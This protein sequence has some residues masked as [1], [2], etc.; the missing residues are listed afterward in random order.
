MKK[1]SVLFLGIVTASALVFTGCTQE[2]QALKVYPFDT[3]IIQYQI[4]GAAEGDETL[5]IKGD[6]KA[7]I[8]FVTQDDEEKQT[9]DLDLGAE[10]YRVNLNDNTAVKFANDYYES[11]KGMDKDGQEMFL[12]RQELGLK[13]SAENPTKVGEAKI[14][15]QVCNIYDVSNVGSVCMWNG[16]PLQKQ[17]N[18]LG[19]VNSK[20]AV[21]IQTDV[22]IGDDRF[23]LPRGVVVE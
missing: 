21:N 17:I 12:V 5:Y 2:E 20:T 8:R 23:D 7:A 3:A 22:E 9:M 6:K 19:V 1:L 15:G 16:I 14:A 10:G 18:I 11:L 13:E 4:A